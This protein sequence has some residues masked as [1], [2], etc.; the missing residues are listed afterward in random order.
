M[1]ELASLPVDLVVSSINYGENVSTCV[2]VSGTILAV[3]EAAEWHVQQTLRGDPTGVVQA[4]YECIK[5]LA[6]G[7]G[8][9]LAPSHNLFED[10]P[11][12]NVQCMLETARSAGP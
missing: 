5:V 7:G 6:L 2:S 8:Y 11:L 12:G 1:L 4:M 9:I 10:V 3:L